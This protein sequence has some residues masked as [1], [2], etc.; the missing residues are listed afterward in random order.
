MDGHQQTFRRWQ[1]ADHMMVIRSTQAGWVSRHRIDRGEVTG[2][3][4]Q[5]DT[6]GQLRVFESYVRVRRWGLVLSRQ[7]KRRTLFCP[8]CSYAVREP[9]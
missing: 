2:T 1:P 5:C 6:T 9:R 4:A 3:C 7:D 8:A